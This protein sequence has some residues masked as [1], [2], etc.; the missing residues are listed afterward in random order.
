MSDTPDTP[1]SRAVEAMA[2]A[3]FDWH[4]AKVE[5]RYRWKWEKGPVMRDNKEK[6]A[7]AALRSLLD[8]EG[9]TVVSQSDLHSLVGRTWGVA[10][11]S[12]ECPNNKIADTIINYVLSAAADPLAPPETTDV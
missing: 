8:A 7:L 4:E 2:R 12:E 10:L 5:P 6:A 3:L 9:L 1:Y 11:E